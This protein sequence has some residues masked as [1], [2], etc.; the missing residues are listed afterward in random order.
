MSLPP[1]GAP[2]LILRRPGELSVLLGAAQLLQAR[3]RS[4]LGGGVALRAGSLALNEPT[5]QPVAPAVFDDSFMREPGSATPWKAA[6]GTWRNLGVGNEE[7]SIN[8]FYYLGKGDEAGALAT[9]GD[10]FWEDYSL[11]AAVQTS[12]TGIG[13][14]LCALVQENGDY[15]AFTADGSK[16]RLVRHL[17]GSDSVLAEADDIL[18][19][20]QWYRLGLRLSSGTGVP[21]GGRGGAGG[22]G[23]P[24][25][26]PS[27][28][29]T[30]TVDDQPVVSCANP[31]SRPGFV[32]L[33]ARNGS[34]RFD[35]VVVR[36]SSHAPRPWGHEGSPHAVLPPSLGAHDMVTW[37][38]PATSWEADPTRPSFLW[39][40]GFFPGDLDVTL[41]VEP[42]SEPALRRFVFA[43]SYASPENERLTITLSLTPDSA[44]L[45]TGGALRKSLTF[46][47]VPQTPPKGRGLRGLSPVD[48]ASPGGSPVPSS[49]L[50]SRRSGRLTVYWNDRPV[51]RLDDAAAYRRIGLE[52]FGP[53]VGARD[54][55]ARSLTAHDY[56]FGVAP[57][58][59]WESAGE[60][61]ISARWACD[62]RWS[63]LAG[64]ASGDAVIWNKRRVEGD[65]AVDCWMGTKMNAPGGSET[66]RCRDYNMVICGDR[67][68]P[69]SGY[70][71]IIGGDGGV[72]TQLLRNGQVVAEC[73][74]IRVPAGYNVHHS[75][76]RVR[77]SRIGNVVSCDFERRPVFRYEDPDPLPGGYVGLWTKNSGILVPRVTI[78]GSE[79]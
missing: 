11:T 69:R 47:T 51:L 15:V 25:G 74:D 72:K 34:A 46:R 71:F 26:G 22:T 27:P 29:L 75:W 65:Q 6:G 28:T 35:D 13:V 32:G 40:D 33:L 44:T 1:E 10:W 30:A 37:G 18:A 52:V 9:A 39:H 63:W 12:G 36:P 60:W 77:M 58:D 59:W 64:W 20:K 76:F 2:L 17:A 19:P 16:A 21:A 41:K 53:P 62:D 42:V 38:S 78:W 31:E 45:G 5:C 54:L 49:L 7:Y 43:P 61:Q 73:P 66:V 23:V 68:N 3:V 56:V 55:A 57:T 79:G 67:E 24:A 70:S 4:P 50:L 48:V 8:G 14:G